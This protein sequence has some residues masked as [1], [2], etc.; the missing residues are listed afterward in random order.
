MRERLLAG[1]VAG[2]VMLGLGASPAG[3]RDDE[4]YGP[5]EIARSVSDFFGVTT[6]AAA[7]VVERVFKDL[8]Q[9]DAYI[10]GKEGSGAFIAGVRY[11]SGL[12]VRKGAG[13]VK[14]Y[15]KGPS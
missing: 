10:K 13:P 6:E 9:P 5:D 8:G 3:A 12:L 14:V 15:W 7:K 4:T 11:G 1:L 2:L